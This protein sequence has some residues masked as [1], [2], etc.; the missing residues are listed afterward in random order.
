MKRKL[1]FCMLVPHF[2]SKL[3]RNN[4]AGYTP[5]VGHGQKYIDFKLHVRTGRRYGS[6]LLV[7]ARG[8]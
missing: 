3:E 5:H 7:R 4:Y 2:M 1:H 6:T 8:K